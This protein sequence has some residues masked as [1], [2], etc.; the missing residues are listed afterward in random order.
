MVKG[1]LRDVVV[2]PITIKRVCG[3]MFFVG[4]GS[5]RSVCDAG[6]PRTVMGDASH[7]T[8]LNPDDVLEHPDDLRFVE[9]DDGLLGEGVEYVLQRA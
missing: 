7:V 3:A 2:T 8:R 4:Y 5:G 6:S 9:G 1:F